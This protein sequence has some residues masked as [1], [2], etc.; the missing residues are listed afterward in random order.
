MKGIAIALLLA[1]ATIGPAQVGPHPQRVVPPVVEQERV[2]E[3]V[4]EEVIRIQ[5]QAFD[6]RVPV[7]EREIIR[8]VEVPV[9]QREIVREAVAVPVPVFVQAVP[10]CFESFAFRS[11]CASSFS[12]DSFSRFRSRS[13]FS[14]RESFRSESSFR[15]G[16]RE[17]AFFGGERRLFGGDRRFFGGYGGGGLRGRGYGGYR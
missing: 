5:P 14:F 2:R 13:E 16:F 6:V 12:F 17:R 7:R 9:I 8:E 1:T 10:V 11:P 4:R 15:E 3:R